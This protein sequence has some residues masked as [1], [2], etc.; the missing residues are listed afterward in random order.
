MVD[1]DELLELREGDIMESRRMICTR[2]PRAGVS[3]EDVVE[4]LDTELGAD[5]GDIIGG[6]M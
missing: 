3:V 2:L 6:D 1:S 4:S 5:G